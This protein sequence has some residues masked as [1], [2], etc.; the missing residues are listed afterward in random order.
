M[1]RALVYPPAAPAPVGSQRRGVDGTPSE[2]ADTGKL[3][4]D[5]YLTKLAKYVPAEVIAFFTPIAALGGDN[6]GILV[7][8][9]CVGAVGTVV[10]LFIFA[11]SIPQDQRPRIWSYGLA[12]VAFGVWALGI[13]SEVREFLGLSD[14]WAG[15]ILATTVFALPAL[16]LLVTRPT[17]QPDQ[18]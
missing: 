9:L 12:V 17:P 14:D 10:W 15:V 2:R 13:S 11:R 3:P 6:R 4:P 8:A 16:D 1:K 5:D 18:A 7:F